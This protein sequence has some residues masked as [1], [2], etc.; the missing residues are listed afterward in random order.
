M[1]DDPTTNAWA[2]IGIVCVATIVIYA[3]QKL[4]N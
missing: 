1:N 4:T 2:A 3:I